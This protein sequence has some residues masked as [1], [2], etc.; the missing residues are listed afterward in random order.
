YI[1]S[2]WLDEKVL[3]DILRF[4]NSGFPVCLK[5]NPS[6][7]GVNKTRSFKKK[8]TG[9]ISLPNVSSEFHT[10]FKQDP[11]IALDDESVSHGHIDFW[12]RVDGDSLLIFF[13]NPK[14]SK[15]TYPMPYGGSFTTETVSIPVEI[16]FGK[17]AIATT[18]TFEPYQSI[19]LEISPDGSVVNHTIEFTP[20]TP[21]TDLTRN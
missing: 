10:V 17:I 9:L 7:A 3:S 15:I 21:V 16:N 4:A 11:I 20:K 18:L 6:Q 8:L 13:A 14:S 19:L 2:L 5:K 12:C 1:D